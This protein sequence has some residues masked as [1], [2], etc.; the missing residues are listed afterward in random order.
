MEKRKSNIELLR[1]IAMMLIVVHHFIV[2]GVFA[3]TDTFGGGNGN[4]ESS[5]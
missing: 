5:I 3:N 1:I 4:G 2:H